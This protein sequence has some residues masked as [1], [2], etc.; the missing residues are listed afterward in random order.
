MNFQYVSKHGIT[1]NVA[2]DTWLDVAEEEFGDKQQNLLKPFAGELGFHEVSTLVSNV[3]NESPD[4]IKPLS[5]KEPKV[6]QN[7]KT[8]LVSL[9]MHRG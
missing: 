4:C 2:V 8:I 9:I 1:N 3:K 6:G 7:E 5:E